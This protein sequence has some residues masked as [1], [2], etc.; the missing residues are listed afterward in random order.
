MS[1]IGSSTSYIVVSNKTNMYK[2]RKLQVLDITV[3]IVLFILACAVGKL[4]M[5]YV[6]DTSIGF[7]G[8]ALGIPA[9]GE[10]IWFYVR[11][12]LNS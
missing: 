5:T 10:L 9:V 2:E 12:K 3:V 4:V 11:R 1:R 7:N 6:A 8:S